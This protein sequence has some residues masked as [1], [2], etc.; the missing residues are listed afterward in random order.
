MQPGDVRATCADVDALQK[1]VGFAPNTPV[2]D[3]IT[4]FIDWYRGYHRV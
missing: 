2:A 1:A 4:R 3:G